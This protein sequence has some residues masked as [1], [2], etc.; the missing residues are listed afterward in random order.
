MQSEIWIIDRNNFAIIP[1]GSD[2]SR[3]TLQLRI[4]R[5]PT[6][7]KKKENILPAPAPAPYFFVLLASTSLPARCPVLVPPAPW[8]PPPIGFGDHEQPQHVKPHH[9][10]PRCHYLRPDFGSAISPSPQEPPPTVRHTLHHHG[11]SMCLPRNP[12]RPRS[13]RSLPNPELELVV[14]GAPRVWILEV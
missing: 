8:L 6:T 11:Q 1:K 12:S 13:Q 3:T 14:I 5:E 4:A 9:Q 2:Y 10:C 7:V